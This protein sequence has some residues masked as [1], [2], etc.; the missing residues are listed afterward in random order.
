VSFFFV[1]LSLRHVSI[2]FAGGVFGHIEAVQ[3]LQFQR[4]VFI[5]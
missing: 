1:M 4:H 5:D 3:P 2:V